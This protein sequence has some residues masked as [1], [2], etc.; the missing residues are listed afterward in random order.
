MS[1]STTVAAT[2]R[3]G[4]RKYTVGPRAKKVS[5][6]LPR[7]PRRGVIRLNL[8]LAAHGPRQPGVKELLTVVRS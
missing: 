5:I 1:V 6:A 4:G 2:L 3:A 7:S 8:A